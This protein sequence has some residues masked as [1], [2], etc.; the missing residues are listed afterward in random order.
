MKSFVFQLLAMAS[1]T[2]VAAQLPQCSGT[3]KCCESVTPY[4][5]LSEEERNDYGLDPEL[6]DANVCDNGS[7]VEDEFDLAICDSV[8]HVPQ[9]CLAFVPTR[10]L[11]DN[12]SFNCINV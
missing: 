4:S 12:L 8:D 11:P 10:A 3:L 5:D 7:L 2:M 6:N 9:C 1:V